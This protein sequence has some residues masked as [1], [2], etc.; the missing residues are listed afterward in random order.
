MSITVRTVTEDDAQNIVDLLTP[1]I[2]TQKYTILDH[3]TKETQRYF[4]Q[5]F[6]KRGIFHIAICNETQDALGIQDITPISPSPALHHVGEIATF[7]SLNNHR[8]GVGRTLSQKTFLAAKE[9]GY[10][11][12][13]AM[14]RADNAQ[15]IAFYLNQG[16]RQ[17]GIAEKHAI[18]NGQYIDEILAEK[19]LF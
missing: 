6:P 11:K 9:M 7:V 8:K 12:I 2:Q 17:I 15:A 18:I 5:T 1:I 13:S 3:V 19:L 4:I 10:K 16:F 14:I